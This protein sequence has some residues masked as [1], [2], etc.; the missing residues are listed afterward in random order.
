MRRTFGG[1]PPTDEELAAGREITELDRTLAAFDG[2]DI[3]AT[4]GIFSYEM[5]VPGGTLPCGGVTRVTVLPTHRRRG[6]LTAMMRQQLDD[7]QERGEPVAALFASEAPI[8]GRFGYGLST[9]QADLELERFRSAFQEAP[10][11]DG[12]IALV[13]LH[14]AVEAFAQVWDDARRDQ[15]GTMSLN[16]GWWR[17]ELSDLETSRHGATPEYRVLYEQGGRP[18]GFALYRIKM[19]W[20]ASG[21]AGTMSLRLLIASTAEAYAALWHYVL[22]VDLVVKVT[23][24]QRP[25][26]EPLRFLLADS[27]QPRTRI[28]DGIW[29]RLVDVARALA[30]RRYAVDGRLILHVSDAF[31]PWNEGSY[32]LESEVDVAHCR[33]SN[34]APD[35]EMNAADLAA[36]YLG[37]NRFRVLQ[38]AGR[39]V[40]RRAGSVARADLMFATDRAPWCPSHF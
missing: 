5:T 29:L 37:G 36:A 20:N 21:P 9:Y 30:G 8:Y 23:A 33:R 31:C 19:D 4:A 34:K 25:V 15:P 11:A 39:V 40:E 26:D 38:Q 6:I 7:M 28:E 13:D 10:G 27:R 32:E 35:L 1:Q 22:N 24:H 17:Y 3:V 14:H 2:G 16:E 18:T 12:R